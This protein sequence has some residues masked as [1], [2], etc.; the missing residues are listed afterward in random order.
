MRIK[1]QII[2]ILVMMP[3][4]TMAQNCIAD[5]SI[6]QSGFHPKTIEDALIDVS[7]KQ[8]L[9]IRVFKDTVVVVAGNP[10]LATIDSIKVNDILGLPS[11]FYYTCSRKNCSYIPDSTGCATL[12]GNPVK[13][14]IG[15]YPL[16]VA[17]EV[18]AKVF[19]GIATTQKDT[20]GQFTV[21]VT[22]GSSVEMQL[23]LPTN[24]CLPNPSTNGHFTFN[25]LYINQ[26]ETVKCYNAFGQLIETHAQTSGF[27]IS[28]AS[29]LY[30]VAIQFKNGGQ[31]TEKV[32]VLN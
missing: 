28:G 12:F 23:N 5:Q 13:S 11:G 15:Y 24:V 16:G 21:V 31:V 19:G 26:I 8:V 17:I 30:Y 9:Q 18:F 1:L 6:K 3:F 10:T 32:R 20:I 7:Y 22:D 2:V 29:G 27:E 14:Q 4:L 25:K